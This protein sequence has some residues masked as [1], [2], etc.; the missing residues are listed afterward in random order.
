MVVSSNNDAGPGLEELRA[1]DEAWRSLE[2]GDPNE[3]FHPISEPMLAELRRRQQEGVP[4]VPTFLDTWNQ[5]SRGLGAGQGLAAGWYALVAGGTGA[6]KTL[7]A[8]NL[9]KKAMEEGRHVLFFSLEMDWPTL[10]TRLRAIVS[11]TDMRHLEPGEHFSVERAQEADGEI[12]GLPGACYLNAE[13]IWR[14]EDIQK[15]MDFHKTT[16]DVSLVVVDYAQ[17][18]EPSGSDQ[19]LFQAMSSISAKLRHSAKKLDLVTVALSQL[20][21]SSTADRNRKPTVDGLYGSSRFGFDADQVLVLDYSR[22]ERTDRRREERTWLNLV[23]NRHGPTCEIP[24][25]FDYSTLQI[26]EALPNE[27]VAWP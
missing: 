2:E 6:G 20:N 26:R 21:R 15:V 24:V 27:E 13:P 3:A 12:L 11:G 9:M 23:K 14:L 19:E 1:K 10:C 4:V 16:A 18:V 17:L 7:V 22:R 25:E 5:V 8:L